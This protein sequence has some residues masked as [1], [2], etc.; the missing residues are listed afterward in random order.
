MLR[1]WRNELRTW[2]KYCGRLYAGI[3]TGIVSAGSW[4]LEYRDRARV[5]SASSDH[6]RNR[7]EHSAKKTRTAAA[8]A[9]TAREEAVGGM[10]RN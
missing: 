10:E 2:R 9:T 1:A 8:H 5:S 7:D 4:K 3:N 6:E